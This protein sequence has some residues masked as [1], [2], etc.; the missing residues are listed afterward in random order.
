MPYTVQEQPSP[1][2]QAIG[3]GAG[4][5]KYVQQQKEQKLAD[6]RQD[7][8]LA[9]DRQ[10]IGIEQGQYAIQKQQ[11]DADAAMQPYKLKEAQQT[12]AA[13]A[14]AATPLGPLPKDLQ[15]PAN[16]SPQA[17]AD[18]YS[19]LL[20]YLGTRTGTQAAAAAKIAED[21]LGQATKAMD[22]ENS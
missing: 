13:N 17:R 8:Q 6:A 2:A 7:A 1:L 19:R 22:D 11:A 20:N 4:V 10:R 9:M 16:Q 18:Y 5:F 21:Q 14:A 12:V 3:I 15:N